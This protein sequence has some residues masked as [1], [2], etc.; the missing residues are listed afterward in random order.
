MNVQIFEN[1]KEIIAQVINSACIKDFTYNKETNILSVT[2]SHGGVYSYPGI[3]ERVVRDWMGA[4][5]AGKFFN[6]EI[7]Y[8]Y[9]NYAG[10]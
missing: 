4:E 3:P 2:F 9:A 5:S 10:N 6:K 1:N 8:G 7:R